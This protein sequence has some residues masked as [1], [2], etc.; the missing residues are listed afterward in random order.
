MNNMF[1]LQHETIFEANNCIPLGDD[2]FWFDYNS[3]ILRY[4]IFNTEEEAVNRLVYNAEQN[5]QKAK[6]QL[7]RAYKTRYEFEHRN[8]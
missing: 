1:I 4:D 5:L 7:H 3:Y 2:M 8:V 6:E